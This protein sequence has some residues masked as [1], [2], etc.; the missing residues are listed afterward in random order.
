VS[1]EHVI[2]NRYTLTYKGVTRNLAVFADAGILLNFNEGANLGLL[3][4]LTAI[5]VY[6]L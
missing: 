4:D 3:T 5:Q 2:L 6:E 1:D